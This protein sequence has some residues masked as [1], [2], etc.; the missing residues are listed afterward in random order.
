MHVREGWSPIFSS[1]SR[2]RAD[3]GLVS[4]GRCTA[5]GVLSSICFFTAS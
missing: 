5:R 4:H 1:L 3:I 2:A